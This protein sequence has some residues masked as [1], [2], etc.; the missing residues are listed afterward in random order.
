MRA[1][2]MT[3]FLR[4]EGRGGMCECQPD[5]AMLA[6]YEPPL[7][8]RYDLSVEFLR[9]RR[10][11]RRLLEERWSRLHMQED[12]DIVRNLLLSCSILP[13]RFFHE[14]ARLVVEEIGAVDGTG[15]RCYLYRKFIPFEGDEELWHLSAGPDANGEAVG[16]VAYREYVTA[17]LEVS[18]ESASL[19]LN[20]Q[21]ELADRMIAA[22]QP[23]IAAFDKG[24]AAFVARELAKRR[25]RDE[26]SRWWERPAGSA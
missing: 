11:A 17:V 7:F 14:H 13:L 9:R 10:R 5:A 26:V 3:T 15:E 20:E 6:D 2:Q 8:Q 12:A 18:E 1:Q 19:I 24:L 4:S 22:Q 25:R 16:E 23:R 21:T